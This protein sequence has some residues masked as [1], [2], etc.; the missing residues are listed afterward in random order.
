MLLVLFACTS[1]GPPA[2]RYASA[3]DEDRLGG[4]S[5]V[6]VLAPTNGDTV[7]STF[8]VRFRVGTDVVGVR[9]DAD[10]A[11][12]TSLAA[13]E[14]GES[15]LVATLDTGKH[16]LSLYALDSA[17]AEISRDDLTI[18]VAD[19]GPW[20]LISSPS[21]GAEVANPV[22]FTV[23][24]SED[25]DTVEILADG[26]AIGEAD[27]Q[28]DGEGMLTYTFAGTGYARVIEARSADGGASDTIGVNVT[29]EETPDTSTFNEVV[30]RYLETYPT[31]GTNRYY[32][33]SGS[34]WAGTTRDLWYRDTLVAEG[35]AEG[36]CY[37]VGLTWEVFMRAWEEVDRTTGGDGTI[38]GM[39]VAE[40]YTFRTDWF[41]RELDGPGPSYAMENYGIGEE[42]TD[43]SALQ[44]GDFVQFWRHSGSGHN[45][46]FVGW[47]MDGAEIVG[48]EYWSTQSSTDG[49]GYNS[50]SFGSSGSRIDPNL[51]FAARGW[52]P[53]DWER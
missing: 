5:A 25:I 2:T 41:V 8:T 27:T 23:T 11:A 14:P 35:D 7:E 51:V 16:D 45:V 44:P 34:D 26:W 20:V 38:N 49:V 28:G 39:D 47:L 17:G 31:D 43:Y 15:A 6:R 22:T 13:V 21:D 29:P 52:M 36:R 18:M 40:L 24:S 10:G 37:C 19:D 32:W 50:E 42:I 1:E 9:L 30:W 3:A 12:L 4:E 33:P 53:A 48:L 46:I